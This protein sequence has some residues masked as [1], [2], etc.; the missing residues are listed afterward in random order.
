MENQ[1]HHL[2]GK[3]IKLLAILG[4]A[5]FQ[6]VLFDYFFYGRL[7][8][9]SFPL[10]V[11]LVLCA[12]FTVCH[13][14]GHRFKNVYW[15]LIVPIVFFSLMVAVRAS[16]LLIL[17]NILAT[18]MMLLLLLQLLT[19]MKIR[20]FLFNDYVVTMVI[21]PFH[22]LE[23]SAGFFAD[24]IGLRTI[25]KGH[26]KFNQVLKGILMALPVLFIFLVL[27]SSADMVFNKYVANALRINVDK[28]AIIRLVMVLAVTFIISGVLYFMVGGKNTGDAEV[29]QKKTVKRYSSGL[30]ITIFLGLINALFLCFIIVQLAYLFGGENN[31]SLQGFTYADYARKGFFELIWVAIISFM[32]IMVSESIVERKDDRH[33]LPF[34][35]AG[36]V[37]A[38]QVMIIM[39]AAFKRLGLYEDAY[40]FTE[41][42]L[43]SHIFIVWLGVVFPV[44]IYKILYDH[45]EKVFV[46]NM[47]VS[48]VAFLFA[49]NLLNP[50]AFIAGQNIARIGLPDTVS[51]DTDYLVRLSDDAIPEMAMALNKDDQL[52]KTAVRVI[53]NK[54]KS[55]MESNGVLYSQWQSWHYGRE[56]ARKILFD[57]T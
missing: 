54:R 29:P 45:R 43:Y 10:Y 25:L 38:A 26:A 34:K 33:T 3:I 41:L 57:M 20:D 50:D 35:V 8:G 16:I 18:L 46:R 37:L 28:E 55:Q 48:C 40:G 31:I 21:L 49:L 23:R 32:I 39:V 14:Y 6:G 19:G 47:A 2:P 5:V 56:E 4:I 51:L 44:L 30:Q 24:L 53:F 7:L 15:L 36:T 12:V 13:F 42:R 17:L 27:F 22:I 11:S 1:T 52:V 9:I